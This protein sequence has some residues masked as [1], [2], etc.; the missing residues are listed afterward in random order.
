MK[1]YNGNI[2]V[3]SIFSDDEL[4]RFVLRRKY[5]TTRTKLSKRKLVFI[6]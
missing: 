1:T 5:S 6:I 4:H 2:S 3:E